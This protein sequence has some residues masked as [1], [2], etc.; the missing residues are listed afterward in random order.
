M[1]PAL[2]YTGSCVKRA[3]IPFSKLTLH[4]FSKYLENTHHA[5]DIV[6]GV[7]DIAINK[8]V[9]SLL[10]RMYSFAGKTLIKYSPK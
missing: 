2:G 5:P 9:W 10:N 3:W 6:P 4:S 1:S 8:I 7:R